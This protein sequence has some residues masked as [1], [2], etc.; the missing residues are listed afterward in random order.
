MCIRDRPNPYG[1][2]LGLALPISL[3]LALWAW[4]AFLRDGEARWRALLWGVFYTGATGLIGAGLLASWRRGAWLGAA[5]GVLVA[6][7]YTHL[8]VYKR[9]VV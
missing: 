9:Q 2:F 8:D 6:V 4:G 5:V 1:G 3:S 7:S